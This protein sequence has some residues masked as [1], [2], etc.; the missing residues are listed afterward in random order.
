MFIKILQ[1]PQTTEVEP[2]LCF[3]K[4]TL[5]DP[6]VSPTNWLYWILIAVGQWYFYNVMLPEQEKN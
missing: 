4:R 1:G 3:Y 6:P 5:K 2:I